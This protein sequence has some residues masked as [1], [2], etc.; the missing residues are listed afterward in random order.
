MTHLISFTIFFLLRK[1]L[2][3]DLADEELRFWTTPPN[4]FLVA[5]SR[6]EESKILGC[7][8]YKEKNSSTVQMHRLCVD[9]NLRGLGI[10]KK[11]VNAL[12][13][14]AKENGYDTI[15]L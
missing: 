1:W 6:G 12:E 4:A 3:T 8:S 7:I 10:G 5:I 11:L 9:P 14:L 13:D 2:N 15:H